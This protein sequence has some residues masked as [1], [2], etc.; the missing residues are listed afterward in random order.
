[1]STRLVNNLNLINVMIAKKR[2]EKSLKCVNQ[3]KKKHYQEK[4]VR[5]INEESV[6]EFENIEPDDE[7]K[8]PV[9]RNKNQKEKENLMKKSSIQKLICSID[10]QF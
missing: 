5:K 6:T 9:I 7:I 8:I 3:Q 4:Y 1:M 2:N 10:I